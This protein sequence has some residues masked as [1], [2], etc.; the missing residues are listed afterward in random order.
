MNLKFQNISI[1]TQKGLEEYQRII[2]SGNHSASF[3][4]SL[5]KSDADT[6][7]DIYIDP[8]FLTDRANVKI[9]QDPK[10]VVNVVSTMRDD[11]FD[12]TK[13]KYLLY[14]LNTNNVISVLNDENL[15][16]IKDIIKIKKLDVTNDWL[17]N[18]KAYETN[19]KLKILSF[20]TSDRANAFG[21]NPKDKATEVLNNVHDDTKLRELINTWNTKEPSDELKVID[22]LKSLDIDKLPQDFKIDSTNTSDLQLLEKSIV[23]LL[24]KFYRIDEINNAKPYLQAIC[25]AQDPYNNLR[26]MMLDT[27]I[28]DGGSIQA[29]QEATV[30]KILRT[31]NNLKTR[32]LDAREQ[33]IQNRELR[34]RDK[35]LRAA[36]AGAT[37]GEILASTLGKPVRVIG[38]NDLSVYIIDVINK[39]ISSAQYSAIKDVTNTT[40]LKNVLNSDSAFLTR[41]NELLHKRYAKAMKGTKLKQLFDGDIRNLL[42]TYKY[43]KRVR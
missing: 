18:P 16:I 4:L 43:L 17:Y 23:A 7:L 8:A 14:L 31:F 37:G 41:F 2:D 29:N 10:L 28:R 36:E 1:L 35:E 42:V 38:P 30:E 34:L 40:K 21:D 39:A 15:K 25:K 5:L 6:S 27:V 33:D 32:D 9:L 22:I 24:K 20:L 3:L 13:N 19:Y 12:T 26:Q 11:G